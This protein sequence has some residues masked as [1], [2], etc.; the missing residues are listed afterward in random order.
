[1][2]SRVPEKLAILL[3]VC[4]EATKRNDSD[5]S[6]SPP[7]LAEIV[8]QRIEN[9]TGRRIRGLA[10]EVGLGCLVLRGRVNSYHVKQLAQTGA[11]EALP[12]AVLENAIVV[13]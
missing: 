4:A 11:Q 1:M 3:A 9:R 6:T 13:E 7:G 5:M 10:V 12:D 2:G 8:M